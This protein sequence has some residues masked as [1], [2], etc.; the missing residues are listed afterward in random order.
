MPIIPW[1]CANGDASPVS[2]PCA[3][4]VALAPPDNSVDTNRV[5]ITGTGTITSFGPPPG[6]QITDPNAPPVPIGVTKKVTFEP[7][8]SITLTHSAPTLVLLGNASRTI[9]AKSIG[10]YCCDINGNWT[11]ESFVDTSRAP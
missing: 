5:V 4:T 10:V 9:T 6:P 7:A 11:E 2:L 1:Q 8:P 3:A